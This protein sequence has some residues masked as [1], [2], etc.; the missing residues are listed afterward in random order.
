MWSACNIHG[1]VKATGATL[2]TGKITASQGRT[3]TIQRPFKGHTMVMGLS[4]PSAQLCPELAI[5]SDPN[6]GDTG[7]SFHRYYLCMHF[8]STSEL[9]IKKMK[10]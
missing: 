6:D 9:K 7:F 10:S 8:K 5:L 2:D 3:V 1:H 4:Q